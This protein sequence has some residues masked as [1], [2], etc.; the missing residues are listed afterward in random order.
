MT[1]KRTLALY[2]LIWITYYLNSNLIG[3][4]ILIFRH[5][6]FLLTAKWSFLRKFSNC[7]FSFLYFQQI[8]TNISDIEVPKMAMSSHELPES[9]QVDHTTRW[10]S[11]LHPSNTWCSP[12]HFSPIIKMDNACHLLGT[13]GR[14]SVFH[15]FHAKGL[16]STHKSK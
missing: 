1:I 14:M 3:S 10:D 7:M 11:T 2:V 12:K 4:P 16:I 15:K 9:H 5:I 6:I 13:M 8:W